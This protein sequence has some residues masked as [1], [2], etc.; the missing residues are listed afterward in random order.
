MEGK[1]QTT[2]DFPRYFVRRGELCLWQGR[3]CVTLHNVRRGEPILQCFDLATGEKRELLF[4]A[5]GKNEIYGI[6][7]L[8]DGRTV[9]ELGGTLCFTD[10]L[11]EFMKP[12]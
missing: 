4:G 11:W 6:R 8:R 2:A 5:L 1:P 12:T 9:L 3:L 7:T 10:C